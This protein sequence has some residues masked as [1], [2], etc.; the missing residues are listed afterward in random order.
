MRAFVHAAAAVTI[1]C[2]PLSTVS[3]DPGNRLIDY[4]AF[5]RE[6]VA[7]GKLRAQRRV[8]EAR[9]L[10]M[11]AEPG[12]VVLDARSRER[13]AELHVRGAKNLPFPD[14]T[15]AELAA[16]LPAKTTRVLIYCN[17]NFEGNQKDFA[18]KA[19]IPAD[20]PGR[21]AASQFAAQAKP[22][23]MA[24]NIP[25]YINLYGYGYRNVYELDELVKV[26]DP[27][28][29]FEGTI[30]EKKVAPNRDLKKAE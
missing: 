26:T 1:A 11:A 2:C 24:L 10:R 19:F 23:M 7:A 14:V 8:D 16:L 15:E 6:V 25:T 5:E 30:V 9:F 3:A 17:N 13:Y 27:R 18:T 12:T 21:A 29:E 28:I 4:A 22:L 20:R